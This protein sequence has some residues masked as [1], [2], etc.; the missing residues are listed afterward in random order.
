MVCIATSVLNPDHLIAGLN[1]IFSRHLIFSVEFL[2]DE[3]S[4]RRMAVHRIR[5]GKIGLLGI[6]QW[7]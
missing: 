4:H 3:T 1:P 2:S 5:G 7:P 6:P